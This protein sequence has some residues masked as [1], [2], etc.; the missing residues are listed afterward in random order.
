MITQLFFDHAELSGIC[1]R[2]NSRS[3]MN[4]CYGMF[5]NKSV[6]GCSGNLYGISTDFGNETA[7][8]CIVQ[9]GVTTFS[10]MAS[11]FWTLT[12]AFYFYISISR[13]TSSPS[14]F[15]LGC[16]VLLLLHVLDWGL[17]LLLTLSAHLD[18]ALGQ[19]HYFT[20][21]FL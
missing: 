7:L 11:F 6:S 18:S 19:K 12:I 8:D 16:K 1:R 9:S 20:D 21:Q 10:S 17:P 13:S 15:S 14:A 5:S 3:V 4:A 2:Q